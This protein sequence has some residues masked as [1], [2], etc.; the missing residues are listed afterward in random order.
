MKLSPLIAALAVLGLGCTDAQRGKII[1]LG[2]PAAI[3]CYSG[4]VLIYKGRS[5]GKVGSEENSDGYYFRDKKT[6]RPMEVSGDCIIVYEE[7]P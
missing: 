1:A 6:N 2:S 7:G 4:G 5:T 3:Q